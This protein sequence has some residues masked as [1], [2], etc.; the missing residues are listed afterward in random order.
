MACCTN[1][2]GRG[3]DPGTDF[4]HVP[5]VHRGYGRVVLYCVVYFL[6]EELAAMV[7]PIREKY[8]P[9]AHIID[10]HATLVFPA[11]VGREGITRHVEGVLSRWDRFAVRF[12]GLS[13]SWDQWLFLDLDEESEAQM[14]RLHDDIYTGILAPHLSRSISYVPHVG[15]GHFGQ[16]N[17]RYDPLKPQAGSLDEDRYRQGYAEATALQIDSQAVV[18]Q[19]DLLGVTDAATKVERITRFSLGT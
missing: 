15:L 2:R 14:T 8:D 1:T 11:E 9:T 16:P 17:Q 18:E 12:R 19:L 6:S 7:Q 13:Q 5:G 4:P 10:P 3:R